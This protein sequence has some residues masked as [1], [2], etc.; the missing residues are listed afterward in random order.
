MALADLVKDTPC[1]SLL[2]SQL[3]TGRRSGTDAVPTMFDF[4]E[5]SQI[6]ND[7]HTIV[8]LHRVFD[9]KQGHYT[10]DGVILVPKQRF[11]SPCNI[12]AR[13]DPVSASW[14]DVLDYSQ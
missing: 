14:T 9:E 3:N 10:D 8:L 12:Q 6:E 11:G 4:R 5:S 1:H 7:A 13:F 2:L